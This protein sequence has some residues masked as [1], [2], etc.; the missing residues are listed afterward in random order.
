MNRV[1]EIKDEV[2]RFASENK[3]FVKRVG[4]IVGTT[5]CAATILGLMNANRDLKTANQ[6]QVQTIGLLQEMILGNGPEE[7]ED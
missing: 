7:L 2:L 1:T 3:P 4:A 5:A 6:T